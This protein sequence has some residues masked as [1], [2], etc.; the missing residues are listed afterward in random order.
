MI[1]A[2]TENGGKKMR[3]IDADLM[4]KCE[5]CRHHR[6]GGCNTYC[7]H[8]EEYSPDMSKLPPINPED[9]RPRGRWIETE[10]GTMCSECNKHPFEDGEF[11]IANYNGNYCPNCGAN[12]GGK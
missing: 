7:D 12:N 4:F 1:T 3:I 10:E 8:G 2:P 5:T 9:L 6:S 11:S